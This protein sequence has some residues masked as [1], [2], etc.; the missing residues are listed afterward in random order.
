M[1]NELIVTPQRSSRSQIALNLLREKRAEILVKY[2]TPL[3][4]SEDIDIP[5]F[6]RWSDSVDNYELLRQVGKS[7]RG[8]L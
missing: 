4:A 8:E 6:L 5:Y 7:K 2:E 3:V 1:T